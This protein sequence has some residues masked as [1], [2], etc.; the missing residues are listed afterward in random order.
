MSDLVPD[1]QIER[2]VGV[3]RHRKAH[4]GRAVSSEQTVYVLH[5]RECRDSGRD[6]RECRYSVALDLGID[7]DRWA[8][9]QDVPVVLG[10]WNGR[11]IPLLRASETGG[12]A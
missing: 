2:I 11:L 3:G 10:V 6:L 7:P 9:D 12:K 1:D 5:S 8:G 4:F